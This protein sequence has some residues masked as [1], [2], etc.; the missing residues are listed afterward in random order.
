[1]CPVTWRQVRCGG[2]A[3]RAGNPAQR[4]GWQGA[5]LGRPGLG[6]VLQCGLAVRGGPHVAGATGANTFR[7]Q[8]Q[9]A[10]V[11][12]PCCGA[13]CAGEEDAAVAAAG[14]PE[15]GDVTHTAGTVL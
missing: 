13:G 4:P 12:D 7:V 5:G 11:W 8:I 3:E 1:M 9:V 10:C 2:R 14:F 6:K 15:G